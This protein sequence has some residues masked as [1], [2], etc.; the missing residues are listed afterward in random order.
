M[1]AAIRGSSTFAAGRAPAT[2][3]DYANA[4][5]A[6]RGTF[7]LP[8]G[9]SGVACSPGPG[10]GAG[11]TLQQRWLRLWPACADVLAEVVTLLARLLHCAKMPPR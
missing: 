4:L 6:E 8:I 3:S 9:G 7:Q 5:S 10:C 11:S 1:S 2:C